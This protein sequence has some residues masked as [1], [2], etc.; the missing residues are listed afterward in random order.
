MAR[1]GTIC[2]GKT[3][4]HLHKADNMGAHNAVLYITNKL[5]ALSEHQAASMRALDQC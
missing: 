3:W 2:A 5:A 1:K 4:G